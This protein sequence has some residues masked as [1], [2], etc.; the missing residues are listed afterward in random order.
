MHH[1]MGMT[2]DEQAQH[3]KA[4]EQ[5]EHINTVLRLMLRRLAE[6]RGEM[7]ETLGNWAQQAQHEN[8]YF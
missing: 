4:K 6:S 8:G 5:A 3:A 2:S 1:P 7:L